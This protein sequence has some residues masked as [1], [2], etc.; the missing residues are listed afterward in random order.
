MTSNL[1]FKEWREAFTDN[2]Q[3]GAAKVYWLMHG[4]YQI[5]LDVESY[6]KPKPQE[7]ED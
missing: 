2:K 6:R 1:A 3:L 4:A 5:V 7:F